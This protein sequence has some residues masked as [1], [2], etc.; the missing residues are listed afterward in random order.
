MPWGLQQDLKL[1]Q[2]F[3]KLLKQFL[4]SIFLISWAL[5]TP[6]HIRQ[7][8]A[9]V[10]EIDSFIS[11]FNGGNRLEG[12]ELSITLEAGNLQVR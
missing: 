12:V 11:E 5:K 2:V 9:K 1:A 6:W 8:H 7:N 10:E 3:L 4:S